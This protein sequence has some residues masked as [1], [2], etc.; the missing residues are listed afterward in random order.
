MKIPTG[1]KRKSIAFLA[2][3]AF[4]ARVIIPSC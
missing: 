2:R 4:D 3:E 1:G